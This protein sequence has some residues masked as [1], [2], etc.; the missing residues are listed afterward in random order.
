MVNLPNNIDYSKYNSTSGASTR[1]WGPAAWRFLFTSIM[2]RYPVKIDKNKEEDI[3]IRKNFKI[4][5]CSLSIIMP[6][7]YCRKSFEQ[8][9]KELPIDNYLIGRIELMYWL[10]LI[11][12]KINTKLIC[13]EKEAYIE[14]KK[15]LKAL[16][17]NKRISENEYYEKIK[18]CKKESF[19]TTPTP[20]FKQILDEYEKVRASCSNKSKTCAL[21]EFDLI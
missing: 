6:C 7:I 18:K 4:L 5:M 16:Y 8:F 10:Y 12:D 2:A 1:F 14:R 11:K 15:S 21:P 9:I 17:Y 19:K 20:D 13:Q 3:L